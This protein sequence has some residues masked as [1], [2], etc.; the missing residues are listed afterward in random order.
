MDAVRELAL[1][2]GA[3]SG[4]KKAEYFHQAFLNQIKNFGRAYEI[5]MLIEYKLKSKDFMQDMDL[6]PKTL[7]KGKLG[8]L[9]HNVKG[10][11]GIK[12]IFKK[13]GEANK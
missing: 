9:P 8:M 4:D 2:Y 3:V 7:L 5:G 13:T 10:K 11:K 1:V 6:A 12:K